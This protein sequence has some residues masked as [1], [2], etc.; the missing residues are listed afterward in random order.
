MVRCCKKIQR[1]EIEKA[2]FFENDENCRENGSHCSSS[3]SRKREKI[4]NNIASL[5][6]NRSRNKNISKKLSSMKSER[7]KDRKNN[8]Y[9]EKCDE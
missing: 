1:L 9:N 3:V 7:K 6:R 4:K 2:C 5:R 8:Q